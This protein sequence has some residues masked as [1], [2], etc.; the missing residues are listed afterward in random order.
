NRVWER[1]ALEIFLCVSGLCVLC[2][3]VVR[4]FLQTFF[5]TMPGAGFTPLGGLLSMTGR[6]CQEHTDGSQRERV[7]SGVVWHH[8]AGFP[9]RGGGEPAGWRAAGLVG[10]EG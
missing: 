6:H 4:S 1:E 3:S 10:A 9:G 2:A 7:V 8:A 5:P